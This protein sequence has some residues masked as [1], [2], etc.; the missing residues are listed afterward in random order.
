[1]VDRSRYPDASY[2]VGRSRYPNAS[3]CSLAEIIP[4]DLHITL[5]YF[6]YT[7]PLRQLENADH[8]SDRHLGSNI[9]QNKFQ[10]MLNG[11]KILFFQPG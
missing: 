11:I 10:K 4:G 3:Y 6:H 8:R 5:L 9:P 7:K 2:S 1:M